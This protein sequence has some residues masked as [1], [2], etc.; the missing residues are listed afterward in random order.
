MYLLLWAVSNSLEVDV[1]WAL[2]IYLVIKSV[3]YLLVLTTLLGPGDVKLKSE[4]IKSI[5]K[6]L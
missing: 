5:S 3:H 2:V 1:T 4:G 6:C